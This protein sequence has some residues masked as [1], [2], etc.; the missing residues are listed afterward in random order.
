MTVPE[1]RAEVK[2]V[3]HYITTAKAGFGA[4]REVVEILL[5]AR[6]TFDAIVS[7]DGRP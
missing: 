4:A 3:A 2:A 1:G 6:G 7:K 5:R